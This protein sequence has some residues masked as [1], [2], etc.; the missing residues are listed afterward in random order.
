MLRLKS[1]KY[2]HE[3][4]W[5]QELDECSSSDIRKRSKMYDIHKHRW[6]IHSVYSEAI[7]SDHNDEHNK[8]SENDETEALNS[9]HIHKQ[10]SSNL[11]SH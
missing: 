4:Q 9:E 10:L 8:Y 1:V 7:E 11:I 5:H 3:W 6:D 2:L